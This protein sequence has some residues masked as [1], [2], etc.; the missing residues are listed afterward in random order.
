MLRGQAS[1][2]PAGTGVCAGEEESVTLCRQRRV[3]FET[4]INRV[5][6]WLCNLKKVFRLSI[7]GIQN[8]IGYTSF[9]CIL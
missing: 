9:G 8:Y 4:F 2:L 1:D 7:V 3:D 6:S 5:Y